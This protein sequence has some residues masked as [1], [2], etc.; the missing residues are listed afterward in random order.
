MS[1][2]TRQTLFRAAVGVVQQVIDTAPPDV[3]ADLARLVALRGTPG[4]TQALHRYVAR[5]DVLVGMGYAVLGEW[6]APGRYAT[7]QPSWAD[8]FVWRGK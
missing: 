6:G 3:P 4:Y 1:R 7:P 8:M 5:H 2:N